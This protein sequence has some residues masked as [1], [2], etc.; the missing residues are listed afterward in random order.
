MPHAIVRGCY[1]Q[2][3]GAR[4]VASLKDLSDDEVLA[5]APMIWKEAESDLIDRI[6]GRYPEALGIWILSQRTSA[7]DH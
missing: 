6:P 1:W 4:V 5:R 3:G 7:S 2:V